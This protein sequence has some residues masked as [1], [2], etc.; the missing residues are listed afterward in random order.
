MAEEMSSE[1]RGYASIYRR[2]IL[3]L[4]VLALT[5]LFVLG[6]FSLN[7][8]NAI[9]DE[10]ISAG[11]EAVT[12][13]KR[14]SLDTFLEERIGQIK[15][16]AFTHTGEELSNPEKLSGIFSVMQTNGRSYVDM[17]VIG[18]DGRH[19]AYVGPFDL[20]N[21]DY[22]NAPW[23]Q[24]V[25][26]K[27]VVVSDVFLGYRNVPHFIIAVLRHEGTRSFILRATIDMEAM[28]NLLVRV[29]SG[30]R[31]DAFL[32]NE[33]GMLQT[34]SVSHGK[35]MEK[36]DGIAEFPPEVMKGDTVSIATVPLSG[37]G[38]GIDAR[39]RASAAHLKSI[40]WVLVVI[41]D[42]NENLRSL[43]QLQLLIIMFLIGGSFIITI[44]ALFCTRRL[45]SYLSAVDDK[46]A[47]IDARMLQSSKMA[48]LGKMAAGVA[49]E[50]NNP[51]MLIQEN[52]GWIRDLL[53]DESPKTMKNYDEIL[54]STEKI[55][56]HV[57]RAKG[58]TQRMLGFGR[59]MNPGRAEVLLNTLASEACEMLR[60]EA[61]NRNIE[62]RQNYDPRMPII[63]SDMAQLEQVFI[64]IIDNAL[65][66]IGKNGTVEIKTEAGGDTVKIFFTDNGPG[67][68]E[69]TR[70][71]IFDPFFTTKKVGEG[72]GLGLAICY[73]ILEKLGG[74]IDV[75]SQLGKGT[76][77]CITLPHEPPVEAVPNASGNV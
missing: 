22:S 64:N 63:L 77:F 48:A 58:I 44:G 26:R 73:S 49:H 57:N 76:T 68:D 13:S 21:A 61:A 50:V 66:A 23:F 15:T 43:H 4:L 60:A 20:S 74:H 5:P 39:L 45:V 55:D 32:V 11:L 34:E 24:E 9:F 36:F 69:K 54:K 40:P 71:R 3:T 27:G 7:R 19:V 6:F 29:Y 2:M 67:M 33:Q 18:L 28:E 10:K 62:I 42:I 59:R 65:D 52:A 47:M 35:V 1:K 37:E 41:D 70:A 38:E 8:I 51:L 14:R 25:L 30:K 46:K 16:L 56:Q 12:N 17:G 53:E 31:S 72:T 75:R